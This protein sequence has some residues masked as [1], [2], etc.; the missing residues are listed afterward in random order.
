MKILEQKRSKIVTEF[1]DR[2]NELSKLSENERENL[3]MKLIRNEFHHSNKDKY[4]KEEILEVVKLYTSDFIKSNKIHDVDT[5]LIDFLYYLTKP[6]LGIQLDLNKKVATIIAT[7]SRTVAIPGFVIFNFDDKLDVALIVDLLSKNQQNNN[8]NKN[9]E[10]FLTIFNKI[11]LIKNTSDIKTKL[12]E[13]KKLLTIVESQFKPTYLYIKTMYE[14]S[15]NK[16]LGKSLYSLT[17]FSDKLTLSVDALAFYS[18]EINQLKVESLPFFK[19][20][21]LKKEKR[22]LEKHGYLSISNS[23]NNDVIKEGLGC[24]FS[25]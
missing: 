8:I 16:K 7:R 5:A 23:R 13:L 14:I 22:R 3:L 2:F 15:S 12:E 18:S 6:S 4:E 25:F 11:Q 9:D 17:E 10:E 19:R 21:W 24:F 20:A 1:F